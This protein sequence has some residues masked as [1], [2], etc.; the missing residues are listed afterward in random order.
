MKNEVVFISTF[1]PKSKKGMGAFK[2]TTS[3]SGK[4]R[5]RESSEMDEKVSKGVS[6]SFGIVGAC[7][8]KKCAIRGSCE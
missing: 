6:E 2:R 8:T 7:E 3:I 4:L 5:L 1:K